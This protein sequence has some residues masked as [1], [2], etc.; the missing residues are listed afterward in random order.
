[1]SLFDPGHF[2]VGTLL[3]F[4]SHCS[5]LICLH[6]LYPLG[7]ILVDLMHLEIYPFLSGFPVHK[8]VGL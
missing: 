6:G 8:N 3:Q 2:F 1:M 5:G 7:S 4:Q